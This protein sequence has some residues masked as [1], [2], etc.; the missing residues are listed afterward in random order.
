MFLADR[1]VVG[2]CP[3]CGFDKARGDECPKCGAWLDALTLEAPRCRVCGAAPER[4]TTRHWYLRLDLLRGDV[5]Y[6][7]H[8]R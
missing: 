1:Y 8:R 2:T 5:L 7:D 4:R 3:K 6:P